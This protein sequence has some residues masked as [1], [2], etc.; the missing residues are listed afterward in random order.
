[1]ITIALTNYEEIYINR[2]SKTQSTKITYKTYKKTFICKLHLFESSNAADKYHQHSREGRNNWEIIILSCK[3][4]EGHLYHC[5]SNGFGLQVLLFP[6]FKFIG[7]R[8]SRNSQV[9]G[10]WVA[11]GEKLKIWK[12]WPAIWLQKKGI[13]WVIGQENNL[14]VHLHSDSIF[15][16][17]SISVVLV[18]YDF[19]WI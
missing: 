2:T 4:T 17:F 10:T 19:T 18:S 7:P 1:M 15:D 5:I 12:L 13:E 9:D 3:Q 11:L 16:G 14:K 8:H 6:P